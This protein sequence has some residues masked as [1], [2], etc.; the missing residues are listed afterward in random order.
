MFLPPW[1]GKN[2]GYGN[3]GVKEKQQVCKLWGP[4]SIAQIRIILKKE[5]NLQDSGG[6]GSFLLFACSIEEG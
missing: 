5:S 2:I 4:F 6:G 3:V 1:V